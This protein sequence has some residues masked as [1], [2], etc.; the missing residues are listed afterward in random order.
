MGILRFDN[1]KIV[2]SN[3]KLGIISLILSIITI[4]MSLC[5]LS[6]P[7]ASLI[8]NSVVK[9]ILESYGWLR[10]TKV[11]FNILSVVQIL[12]M[13]GAFVL[14]LIDL[15]KKDSKKIFSIISIILIAILTLFIIRLS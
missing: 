6:Y 1:E 5:S 8:H 4:L 14:S 15:R 11:L 13:I 10:Q 3:S 12:V 2:R 9:T 7:Y